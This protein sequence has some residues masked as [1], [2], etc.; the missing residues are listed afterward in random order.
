MQ[1]IR[2]VSE[3]PFEV[4]LLNTEE[5]PLYQRIAS[6]AKHLQG[7]G[8]NNSRIAEHLGVDHMTVA[9]GIRWLEKLGS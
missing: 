3:V 5:P 8:L 6:E 7:L 4:S 2:T 1:R 9:K